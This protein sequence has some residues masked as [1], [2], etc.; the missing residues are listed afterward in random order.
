[1]NIRDR[2]FKFIKDAIENKVHD[3]KKVALRIEN[4]IES[5]SNSKDD[6]ELS[7]T[8]YAMYALK[9][10]HNL[11]DP[12]VIKCINDK[13][14]K[15]EDIA[16]LEKDELNPEKWQ[17]IQDIRLPK[18]IKKERRKGLN[19]CPR[20]KSWYTTCTGSAQLRSADEPMTNF[21][22]CDDCYYRWKM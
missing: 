11:K 16:G 13:K 3:H 8:L 9:V 21:M 17:Q 20:C 7:V 22:E 6:N 15:P 2:T 10:I 19:K 4:G 12:Y 14:W 18:N 5:I 1:M